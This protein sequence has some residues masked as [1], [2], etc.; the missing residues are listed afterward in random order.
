MCNSIYTI[1]LRINYFLLQSGSMGYEVKI[2]RVERTGTCS[3]YIN[4][5]VAVADAIGLNKGESWAWEVE[6]KNTLLF[7]R[8]KPLPLRKK[9]KP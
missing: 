6:D 9:R 3:F 8:S 7:H 4:F 2:Q 5:P 1:T